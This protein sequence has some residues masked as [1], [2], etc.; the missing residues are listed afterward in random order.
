MLTVSQESELTSL[1]DC[2]L[3]WHSADRV[4]THDDLTRL[5]QIAKVVTKTANYTISADDD[6]VLCSG[7]RTL[8]LPLSKNTGKEIVC[9][10]VSVGTMTIATS[11]SDTIRGG[12]SIA[13]AVLWTA[14]R[15]KA[16]AG[17]WLVVN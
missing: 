15:L 6:Y 12:A 8:T 13:T 5:Q 3:H 10:L 1:G 11:G 2:Q 9:V 4:K 16:I 17:S 14:F 7:T